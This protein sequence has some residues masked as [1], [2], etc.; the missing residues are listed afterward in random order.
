MA[1]TFLWSAVLVVVVS[2]AG[3]ALAQPQTGGLGTARSELGEVKTSG[4]YDDP[5]NPACAGFNQP[6]SD[7][8]EDLKELC[9]TEGASMP[10]M[11]V[12]SLWDACKVKSWTIR[13][14]ISTLIHDIYSIY[15]IRENS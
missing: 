8:L 15:N 5:S 4:C 13:L 12:C 1:F 14:C 11:V 9:V 10:F 3:A 7:S 2:E 6:D